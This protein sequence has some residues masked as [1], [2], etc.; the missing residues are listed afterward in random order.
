MSVLSAPHFH[1]EAAAVAKLEAII[2]PNGPICPHCGTLGRSGALGGA[3]TKIGTRK[4][5]ACRKKFTVTV[6]TV[7]ELAHVPL[8]QW[9]QA[10]Y[11]LCS[12]KKGISSHQLMRIMN[13]QYKTAWFMSHR[14]REAMKDG[15]LPPM[16]GPGSI[17]EIDET[18][19][20][21]KPG[22]E[23][24]RGYAHKHAVMTSDRA[25]SAGWRGAVLP[26]LRHCRRRSAADHQSA[27]AFWQ[28][29][30]DGRSRA[31]CTS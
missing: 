14:L 3:S 27:C 6:G 20:G 29:C 21:K 4:C 22:M 26:R 13:V 28:P 31:V 11:L 24:R 17:V 12:S 25:S 1:D 9:L 5:Y 7:F 10:A 18:F 2:W 19:I 23:K 15:K 8:H 16:G 30:D